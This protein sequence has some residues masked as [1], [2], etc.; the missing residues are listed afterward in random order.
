VNNLL[1]GP[2]RY[3]TA[4]AVAQA[5]VQVTGHAPT[6]VGVASGVSF[7][8]ALTGGAYA[9]NAGMPLLITEPYSLSEA[10]RFWLTQWVNLLPAVTVFGGPAAVS[11]NVMTAMAGAVNG[12][13]Q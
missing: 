5:V 3:D 12:K 2:T 1:S 10:T 7:P 11:D 4:V 9:A 8:D 13:V 6:G